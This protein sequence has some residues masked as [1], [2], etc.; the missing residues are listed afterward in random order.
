MPREERLIVAPRRR[1]QPAAHQRALSD[2]PAL[3]ARC[4]EATA[5]GDARLRLRLDLADGRSVVVWPRFGSYRRA[6]SSVAAAIRAA[7]R[8]GQVTAVFLE[9]PLPPR[10]GEDVAG[11][12]DWR[13]LEAW[14]GDFIAR[15]VAQAGSSG[16]QQPAGEPAREHSGAA[17][18]QAS[19]SLEDQC[20]SA[21][22]LE[23]PRHQPE[24]ASRRRETPRAAARVRRTATGD[25][26]Q[27][28]CALGKA[29]LRERAVDGT[30]A[31]VPERAARAPGHPPPSGFPASP[32]PNRLASLCISES[33][34]PP[35]YRLRLPTAV[36]TE[37]DT[38]GRV[39]PR[40]AAHRWHFFVTVAV[41]IALWVALTS[42]LLGGRIDQ[43][44]TSATQAAVLT[45]FELPS[46]A[47]P[48][49]RAA[50]RLHASAD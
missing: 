12:A 11:E 23:R 7:A 9:R 8:L 18:G 36:S 22:S 15:I 33:T 2:A 20:H 44:W 14:G 4:R 35:T 29:V 28:E 42:W 21:T 30:P 25:A 38:P 19:A 40:S 31:V 6:V 26:G 47:P 3:A 39:R 16:R 10:A 17:F 49:F 48:G 46:E 43:L 37:P 50:A 24:E 32:L 34:A 1:P 45:A 5:A 41:M 27:P 13:R